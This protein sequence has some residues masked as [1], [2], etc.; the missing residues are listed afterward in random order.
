[1]DFAHHLD[2]GQLWR[3][4]LG[5]YMVSVLFKLFSRECELTLGLFGW[6]VVFSS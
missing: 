4:E 5:V 1:M 2:S 6:L 3:L